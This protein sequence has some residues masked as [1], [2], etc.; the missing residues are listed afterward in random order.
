MAVVVHRSNTCDHITPDERGI[1][2]AKLP[3]HF[4]LR[5][6][7]SL[8]RWH[9]WV[10]ERKRQQ[11]GVAGLSA[12][13]GRFLPKLGGASRC[14]PFFAYA[15]GTWRLLC[16]TH[17]AGRKALNSGDILCRQKR[18][19]VVSHW[20]ELVIVRPTRGRGAETRERNVQKTYT[21]CLTHM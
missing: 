5:C 15:G 19:P 14:R 1:G 20:P 18:R 13:L 7:T 10:Y 17:W 6:S 4:M 16:V 11:P 12:F 9:P 21:I 3:R 2:T 8:A